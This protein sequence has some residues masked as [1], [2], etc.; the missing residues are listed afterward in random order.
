MTAP[1]LDRLRQQVDQCIGLCLDYV[2]FEHTEKPRKFRLEVKDALGL[3]RRHPMH[4]EQVL[5]YLRSLNVQNCRSSTMSGFIDFVVDISTISL[6]IAQTEALNTAREYGRD[7]WYKPDPYH[8]GLHA[9]VNARINNYIV[10]GSIT[11]FTARE[12][13]V[14]PYESYEEYFKGRNIPF[15]KM[16]EF[17]S[18]GMPLV[19]FTVDLKTIKGLTPEQLTTINALLAAKLAN[20]PEGPK[21]C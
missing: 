13:I 11:G 20:Q 7:Q 21:Q 8:A 4:D 16:D 10:A 1:N 9:I 2:R 5:D 18:A 14:E 17:G 3:V 19:S 6:N 12:C 15:K